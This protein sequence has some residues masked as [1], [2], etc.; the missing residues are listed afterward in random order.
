MFNS[1]A[2]LVVSS[3]MISTRGAAKKTRARDTIIKMCSRKPPALAVR[4]KR[5]LPY[6][7]FVD[8]YRIVSYDVAHAC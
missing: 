2:E 6:Y 5:D 1:V 8:A 7:S 3:A 4:R